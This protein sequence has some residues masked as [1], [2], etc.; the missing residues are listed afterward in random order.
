MNT[1]TRSAVFGAACALVA[2]AAAGS[3]AAE[4]YPPGTNCQSLLPGLRAGCMDQVR[5]LNS[6]ANP[7]STIVPS[8][9]S[10]GATTTGRAPTSTTR[11]PLTRTPS[12]QV[13]FAER[14]RT[15][16]RPGPHCVSS[17]WIRETRLKSR[18]RRSSSFAPCAR[19]AADLRVETWQLRLRPTTTGSPG[20]STARSP[21]K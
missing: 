3:A 19:N 12:T 18:E 20:S 7:D 17:Q 4:N 13:P 15:S 11:D 6:G 5:Q 16:T 2:I 8:A 14:S 1:I 21:S 10:A 9:P